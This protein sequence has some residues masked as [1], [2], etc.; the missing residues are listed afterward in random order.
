MAAKNDKVEAVCAVCRQR[1]RL[2]RHRVGT[3]QCPRC[4]D[5]FEADTNT[6]L[7]DDIDLRKFNVEPASNITYRIQKSRKNTGLFLVFF[8]I[9]ILSPFLAVIFLVSSFFNNWQPIYLHAVTTLCTLSFV[10]WVVLFFGGKRHYIDIEPTEVYY[11]KLDI[12][13]KY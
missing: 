10:S 8:S 6:V 7:L 4:G 11:S 5:R 9:G 2:F 12:A 1:L 13:I 3:V